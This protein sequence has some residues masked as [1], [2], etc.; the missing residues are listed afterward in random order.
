LV[1]RGSAPAA[2]SAIAMSPQL[3]MHARCS[4]VW[5]DASR[6]HERPLFTL[7]ICA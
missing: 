4:I 6:A 7:R 2:S 1:A 3:K 5:P